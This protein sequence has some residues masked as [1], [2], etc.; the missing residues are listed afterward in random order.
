MSYVSG[1]VILQIY[2]DYTINVFS[3]LLFHIFNFCPRNSRIK[4][5]IVIDNV[6]STSNL[7]RPVL[8]VCQEESTNRQHNKSHYNNSI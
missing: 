2:E 8:Y 3:N 5:N 6:D 7:I 4:G 1:P